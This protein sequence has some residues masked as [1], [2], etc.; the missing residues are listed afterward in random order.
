MKNITL[1]GIE[2]ENLPLEGTIHVSEAEDNYWNVTVSKE[3]NGDISVVVCDNLDGGQID[4]ILGLTTTTHT[5]YRDNGE[6]VVIR[7]RG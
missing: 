2:I 7:R 1:G 5:E 3:E 4:L 6:A